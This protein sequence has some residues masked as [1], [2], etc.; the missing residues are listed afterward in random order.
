MNTLPSTNALVTFWLVM[1]DE[2]PMRA[3]SSFRHTSFESAQKEAD[4]LA[5]A[6]GE[7]FFVMKCEGVVQKVETK[8]VTATPPQ[9]ND[10]SGNVETMRPIC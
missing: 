8:W 7:R 3:S 10:S 4:C 6:H 5:K 1:R 2:S 9:D